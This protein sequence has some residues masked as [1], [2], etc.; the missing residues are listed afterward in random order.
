M[1]LQMIDFKRNSRRLNILLISTCLCWTGCNNGWL[2]FA[3]TCAIDPRF[4]GRYL[5]RYEGTC[6]SDPSDT[7]DV[8]FLVN[9]V[10]M[11]F[12]TTGPAEP[13]MGSITMTAFQSGSL[14]P[15]DWDLL[16]F[17]GEES[18]FEGTAT[19]TIT[20]IS[21]GREEEFCHGTAGLT[22]VEGESE[23]IPDRVQL[24]CPGFDFTAERQTP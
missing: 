21:A 8:T 24:S 7:C 9:V 1:E 3:G 17:S 12:D 20:V 4:E 16:L 19:G 2:D 11:T 18:V 6:S 15:Y 5:H 13:C 22:L 14:A 23:T 10:T